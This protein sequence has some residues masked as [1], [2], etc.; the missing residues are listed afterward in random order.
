[1]ESHS[2]SKKLLPVVIGLS[3]GV[4]VALLV[5]YVFFSAPSYEQELKRAAVEINKSGPVMVDEDTRLDRVEVEEGNILRYAY[6][7]VN[8]S[9]ADITI[10]KFKAT[11]TPV[12]VED[13]RTNPQ[14]AINREHH[15]TLKYSYFDREKNFLFDIVVTPHMYDEE[16]HVH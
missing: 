16:N 1:M 5:Q 11:L 6:T 7:L 9:K 13:V 15:T 14:M 2:W 3:I 12:I 10:E 4:S 8:M